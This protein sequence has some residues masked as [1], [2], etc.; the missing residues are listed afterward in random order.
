MEKNSKNDIKKYTIMVLIFV[1]S[2]MTVGV[3]LSYA[4]FTINFS[5]ES[6]VPTE[7]AGFLNVTSTIENAEAISATELGLIDKE[8]Y[9]TKGQ[10]VS[11]TVTNNSEETLK[12]IES[13]EQEQAKPSTINA[14]YTI[15]LVD[16]SISKNLISQY[17]KWAIIINDGEEG[18]KE[19]T[20]DFS[21]EEYEE[22]QIITG[23]NGEQY[24]KPTENDMVRFESKL[25]MENGKILEIGETDKID[26][27]IW[28]E[29]D[30][31]VNFQ[32]LSQS[33]GVDQLYLTNGSFS[34]KLSLDAVPTRDV[35]EKQ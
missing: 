33:T 24:A 35:E 5:G 21:D 20:G 9:K 6:D 8:D 16:M 7:Q 19:I 31:T 28:L 18:S 34:A 12:N 27:Y 25:L 17:F 26:F 30:G 2:I 14:K 29:N 3:S 10:K 32:D 13:P 4:Y 1:I 22:P 23:E 11:F 15:K